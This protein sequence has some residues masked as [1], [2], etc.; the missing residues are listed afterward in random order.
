[1]DTQ[2]LYD[3]SD[4][5][6][7]FHGVMTGLLLLAAVLMFAAFLKLRRMEFVSLYKNRSQ[8]ECPIEIRLEDMSMLEPSYTMTQ[9]QSILTLNTQ[10]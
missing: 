2:R 4:M 3:N 9:S 8:P 7:C 10:P 5:R 6:I 1:M